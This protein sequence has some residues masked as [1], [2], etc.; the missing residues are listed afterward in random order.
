M[1]IDSSPNDFF[2]FIQLQ[3]RATLANTPIVSNESETE[4]ELELARASSNSR[5]ITLAV[6][7]FC[8]DAQDPVSP[9]DA[10]R[11]SRPRAR[12]LV[13]RSHQGESIYG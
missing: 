5:S 2:R 11:C 12:V 4:F 13:R 10:L 6:A 1:P 7:L 8:G 3:P 9:G